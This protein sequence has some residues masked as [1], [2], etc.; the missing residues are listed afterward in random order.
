MSGIN[1]GMNPRRVSIIGYVAAFLALAVN[2][3]LDAI[4]ILVLR[5]GLA[6][7]V[8]VPLAFASVAV[9]CGLQ[10][11]AIGDSK[12]GTRIIL[13]GIAAFI[14]GAIWGVTGVI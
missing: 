11:R 12:W 4:G 8:L 7:S 14:L 10:I 6:I 13:S 2:P 1:V 5:P 3:I 9:V